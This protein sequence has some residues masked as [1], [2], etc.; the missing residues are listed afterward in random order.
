[1]TVLRNATQ[2]IIIQSLS[3]N[4]SY[5]ECTSCHTIISLTRADWKEILQWKFG[6]MGLLPSVLQV[7]KGIC[8]TCQ[9]MNEQFKGILE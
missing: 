2:S 5:L 1:M 4:F 9:E 6:M 3:K 8:P 7:A